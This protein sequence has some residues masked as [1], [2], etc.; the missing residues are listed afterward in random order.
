M[1][2]LDQD[3]EA[4]AVWSWF[5]ATMNDRSFIAIFCFCVIGLLATICLIHHFP[6]LSAIVEPLQQF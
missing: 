5:V 1:R 4:E 2:L 6:N 3:S